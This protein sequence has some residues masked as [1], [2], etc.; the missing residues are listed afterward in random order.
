MLVFREHALLRMA[1]RG[2]SRQAVQATLEQGEVIRHYPED[3][4]Y[5]S[6]LLLHWIDGQP[7]HV[8][9]APASD[10]T[11]IIITVY[12]PDPALWEPDFKRKR[13]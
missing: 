7:L 8:V 12:R 2:I 10:D 9:A 5:P 1:E 6:R 11:E 13:P 4:P 3:T